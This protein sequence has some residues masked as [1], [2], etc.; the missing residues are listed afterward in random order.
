MEGQTNA[1]CACPG[2]DSE[3]H[4]E[5]TGRCTKVEDDPKA[6]VVDQLLCH[7]CRASSVNIVHRTSTIVRNSIAL[8]MKGIIWGDGH[9]YTRQVRQAAWEHLTTVSSE[10]LIKRRVAGMGTVANPFDLLDGLVDDAKEAIAAKDISGQITPDVAGEAR[11]LLD[12]A[13]RLVVYGN[14][15][16]QK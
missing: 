13:R 12:E 8:G 11:H 15:D 4:D 1:H 10:D 3:T 5:A 7:R 14:R 2:C 6:E 9:T 16:G